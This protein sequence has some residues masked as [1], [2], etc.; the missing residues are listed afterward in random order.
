MPQG[1]VFQTSD[2]RPKYFDPIIRQIQDTGITDF[3]FQ[4]HMP[5]KGMKDTND[6]PEEPILLGH[7]F[8]P[9][10]Y[11]IASLLLALVIFIKKY[12]AI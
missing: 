5:P 8:I 12:F 6:I 10:V 4:R 9:L 1:M 11:C 3:Y 2:P 7:I